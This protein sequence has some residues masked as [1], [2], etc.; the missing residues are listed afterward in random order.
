MYLNTRYVVSNRLNLP[1]ARMEISIALI[2]I[3]SIVF[4]KYLTWNFDFWKRCGVNGPT[5]FAY[6]GTYPK[7]ILLRTSNYIRETTEIY[8]FACS[9]MGIPNMCIRFI[10][11]EFGQFRLKMRF[12]ESIQNIIIISLPESITESIDLLVYLNVASRNFSY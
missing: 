4:Y 2:I 10:L 8:R 5:P 6:V 7:T 12:K 3:F 1:R 11:F 9:F